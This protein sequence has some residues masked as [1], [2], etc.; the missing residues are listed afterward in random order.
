MNKNVWLYHRGGRT[1]ADVLEDE[2]GEFIMMQSG[3]NQQCKMY[4]PGFET[5]DNPVHKV[6]IA[7]DMVGTTSGKV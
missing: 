7:V 1:E 6:G 2:K 5:V 4:I 3:R